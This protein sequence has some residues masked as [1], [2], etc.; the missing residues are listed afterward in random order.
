MNN[1]VAVTEVLFRAQCITSPLLTILT[2]TLLPVSVTN[3]CLLRH[4]SNASGLELVIPVGG[5]HLKLFFQMFQHLL[6]N[7]LTEALSK[8]LAKIR[9]WDVAFALDT[10]L[11]GTLT[12]TIS[13]AL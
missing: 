8:T 1:I 12:I 13:S 11:I 2:N 6:I 10:L 5:T 7:L 4:V 3:A 9:V